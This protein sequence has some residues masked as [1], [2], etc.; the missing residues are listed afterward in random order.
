MDAGDVQAG[1]IAAL[2][3]GAVSADVVAAEARRHSSSQVQGTIRR[4]GALNTFTITFQGM[5]N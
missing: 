4:K 1:I 2:G 3:V 5:T